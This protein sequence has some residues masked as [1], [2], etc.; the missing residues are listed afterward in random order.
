VGQVVKRLVLVLVAGCATVDAPP[1]HAAPDAASP[2]LD[3]TASPADATPPPDASSS[4]TAPLP[5]APAEA[6]T[7]T[8]CDGVT[9]A[10]AFCADFDKGK[11]VDDGWTKLV[12]DPGA[13]AQ[14]GLGAKSPPY[15]FNAVTPQIADGQYLHALLTKAIQATVT[16]ATLA[17]DI[18][19][20]K[21]YAIGAN[22]HVTFA[23]VRFPGQN[24][25]LY[26]VEIGAYGGQG[27]VVETTVPN[28]GQPS[29]VMH[30]CAFPGSGV[31][32]RA[33]MTVTLSALPSVKVTYD[34]VSQLDAPVTP[35]FP[36]AAPT[37]EVGLDVGGAL[38][39]A[40]A[41]VDDVTF[42]AK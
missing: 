25:T 10:P 16:S 18:R 17:F 6:A 4:D 20:A 19:F 36:S 1:D 27:Q 40:N 21:A 2:P 29:Y 13:T 39:S 32:V 11:P 22:T 34:G 5:D 9:P 24:G 37:A 41:S 8:W 38:E 14:L 35:P 3:A 23:R 30:A 28:G 7:P 26:L 42:D 12:L 31:F 33:E 15:A